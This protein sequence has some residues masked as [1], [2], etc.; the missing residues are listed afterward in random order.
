M[1]ILFY[2]KNDHL[3]GNKLDFI[4]LKVAASEL[5]SKIIIPTLVWILGPGLFLGTILVGC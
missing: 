2:F 3:V 4:F 1:C 5:G